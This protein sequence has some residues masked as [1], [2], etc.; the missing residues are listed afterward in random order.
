[1]MNEHAKGKAFEALLDIKS[2]WT[3]R[4]ATLEKLVTHFLDHPSELD[5]Q[6]NS[7]RL[8]KAINVQVNT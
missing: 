3:E 2:E 4:D 8:G 1:M 6:H 7:E 5:D